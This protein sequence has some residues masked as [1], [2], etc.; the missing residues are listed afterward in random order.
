METGQKNTVAGLTAA[1]RDY[2]RRELN[3]FFSTYPSVA[4]GFQLRTW[5]G[6]SRAGQAKIPAAAEGL[7]ARGLMRL[8]ASTA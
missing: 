2:I 3:V 4:D 6:S 8:D 5:R 7:I 1:E